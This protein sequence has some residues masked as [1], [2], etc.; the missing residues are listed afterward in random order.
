MHWS[1]YCISLVF[2]AI[3]ISTLLTGGAWTWTLVFVAFGLIPVAE[4]I[5][6]P[7]TEN[8]DAE[9]EAKARDT[10]VYRVIP[11]LFVPVQ[12]S[13]VVLFVALVG[14]GVLSSFVELAGGVARNGG[15]EKSTKIIDRTHHNFNNV[16]NL[17]CDHFDRFGHEGS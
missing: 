12:W 5:L 6:K 17:K 13:I 10:W 11:Q 15:T 2:P 8:W 14:S 9:E 3:T 1:R 16:L 4:L 7:R